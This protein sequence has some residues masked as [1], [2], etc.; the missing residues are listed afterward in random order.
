MKIKKVDIAIVGAG[1]AGLSFALSLANSGLKILLLEQQ[2][3]DLVSLPK[4]DGRDIALTHLSKTI[5]TELEVWQNIP[6]DAIHTIKEAKVINGNALNEPGSTLQFDRSDDPAAPLGYLIA[7][8]QIRQAL[9]NQLH[10]HSNIELMC[11]QTVSAI[12]IEDKSALIHTDKFMIDA[13][14]VVSSDS[15]FSSSRRMMGLSAK[16]KDFGKVMI[17]CNMTHEKSHHNTAQEC[18]RYDKTC[19]ILPLGEGCSS[20]VI[21]V[22]A[23]ESERLLTLDDETFNGEVEL[24]LDTKLGKMSLNSPRTAYPLIGVMSDRF[25]AQRFALIGDAAVGMHPVTAHGFNLGLRSADTLAQLII[26]S[27][28]QGK[29]IASQWLLHQYEARHKLLSK[30]LYDATNAIVSLYTNPAPLAKMLRK[31]GIKVGNQFLPFKTLVTH[32]LTQI[33]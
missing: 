11:E 8:H 9:Y 22:N 27:N 16:M 33:R 17:V 31:T 20:I 30:P 26:K 23:S 14:L 29:D 5:L 6:G 10:V 18:F 24:M 28:G 25:I 1:P 19:A 13:S 21:T 32:R 3:L 12:K 15:R 4:F 2:A 7:N